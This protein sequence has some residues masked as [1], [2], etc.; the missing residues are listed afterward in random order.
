MTG[1]EWSAVRAM[2]SWESEAVM[3]LAVSSS[4]VRR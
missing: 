4:R 3:R 1:Q 2:G